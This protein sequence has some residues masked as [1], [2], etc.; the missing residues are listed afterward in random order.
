MID[1]FRILKLDYKEYVILFKSGS[2]YISFDEDS[3]I[4]NKLFNYKIINLK[5][6]IKIGFPLG[7]IDIVLKK[8]ENLKI[9]YIIID[10]KNIINK[11]ENEN[12][13][14]SN[15]TSSVYEV[16]NI[17]NRIEKI[18]DKL[19]SIDSDSINGVLNQIEIIVDKIY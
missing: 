3:I 1:L 13:V 15:Y 16:I 18:V 7:N 19:K 14:F 6:N 11:Y 10:N 2:F 17:N 4:L 12:N 5:N 8:L 9:N